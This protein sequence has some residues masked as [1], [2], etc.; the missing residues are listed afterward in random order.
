MD[1]HWRG[2]FPAIQE[3]PHVMRHRHAAQGAGRAAVRAVRLVGGHDPIDGE[4]IAVT[5]DRWI[6]SRDRSWGIRPSGESEPPGRPADP[7]WGGM[8][9]LYVPIA[10]DD[11]GICLIVQEEADGYRL[12]ND[13]TRIWPDGRIEQ[14]GWPRI[15]TTY[16]SGT[17]T[18]KS[19]V[20]ECTLPNGSPVTI[21]VESL[22]PVPIHVGGGYGGDSDWGRRQWKGP[23]FTE[24]VTYDMNDPAVVGRV[25]FGLTDSVGRAVGHE[26]G[27]GAPGRLGP[28]RARRPRPRR[29]DWLHRLVLLA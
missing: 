26:V 12:L 9:W 16:V 8:W 13:C 2:L 25:P 10:F 18:P 3:A 24:R 28:R 23:V 21:D 20:I 29:A 11:F 7:A 22:L 14:L 6:G 19:G 17:R 1:L 5:P 15:R 4:E 27:P